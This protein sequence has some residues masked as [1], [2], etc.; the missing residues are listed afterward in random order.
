M[1][2]FIYSSIDR[3]VAWIFFPEMTLT[4]F[5]KFCFFQK[6]HQNNRNLANWIFFPERT[7][8]DVP[9]RVWIFF[10]KMTLTHFP[11]FWG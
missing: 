6:S 7:L 4:H 9:K 10:P 5:P 8:L 1:I 11:D 2:I 3:K